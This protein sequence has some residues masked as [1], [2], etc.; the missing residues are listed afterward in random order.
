M[1]LQILEIA[2]LQMRAGGYDALNFGPIA[3]ELETT[4]ANI[5]YH[6][7]NKAALAMAVSVAFAKQHTADFEKFAS[8]HSDDFIEFSKCVENYFFKMV[9]EKG[10]S[11]CVFAQ[12]FNSNNAPEELTQFG[13][14]HFQEIQEMICEVIVQSQKSGKLKSNLAPQFITMHF[15]IIMMGM[16]QIAVSLESLE[17]AE[18]VLKGHLVSWVTSLNIG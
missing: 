7:K 13:N 9:S 2:E 6:F 17:Q 1:R 14:C 16:R 5:H 10:L 18:M 4:R 3:K 8:K 11:T 15:A 12:I